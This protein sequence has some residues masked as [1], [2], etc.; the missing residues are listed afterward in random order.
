MRPLKLATLIGLHV[1]QHGPNGGGSIL[2]RYGWVLLLI[3]VLVAIA[4]LYRFFLPELQKVKVTEPLADVGAEQPNAEGVLKEVEDE[5]RKG[6]GEV[7]ERPQEARIEVA[8][9]LLEADER[10]VVDALVKAGGSLLQKE[11]S[12][13]TKFS[14]VKTHRV[15]VRLIRRG[16]VT[17]EKYFNTNK[18]TLAEW[19]INQDQ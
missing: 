5:D 13:E 11:I 18:I 15:L 9:R 8:L 16:V 17:S 2:Q 7:P 4:V 6:E 19:L 1:L 3:P 10:Q 14:R 12:W